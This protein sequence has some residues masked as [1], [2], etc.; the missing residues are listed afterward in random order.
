MEEPLALL[1]R[2]SNPFPRQTE[3]F[4]RSDGSESGGY[5]ALDF[6]FL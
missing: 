3:R 1:A 6:I 4:G 2:L 5:V